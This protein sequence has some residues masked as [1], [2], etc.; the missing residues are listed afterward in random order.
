VRSG[1]RREVKSQESKARRQS[2]RWFGVGGM[3]I[4]MTD[5]GLVCVSICGDCDMSRRNCHPPHHQ[6]P[7]EQQLRGIVDEIVPDDSQ[8]QAYLA[9]AR[10]LALAQRHS[11]C[12]GLLGGS[13]LHRKRGDSPGKGTRP[14]SDARD[15]SRMFPQRQRAGRGTCP[16]FRACTCD[17]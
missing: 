17:P 4:S 11:A 13:P 15:A 8:K 2:K 6:S 9:F 12:P 10:E 5:L 16:V 1:W 14:R 3:V 7:H